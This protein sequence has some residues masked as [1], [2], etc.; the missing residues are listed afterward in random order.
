[1]IPAERI[2]TRA[3][4]WFS[5]GADDPRRRVGAWLCATA[6]GQPDVP[7]PD[8]ALPA[9]DSSGAPIADQPLDLVRADPGL[10]LK[11]ADQVAGQTG[12]GRMTDQVPADLLASW[13]TAL[14]VAVTL[15]VRAHD[16]AVT[17]AL[18]LAGAYLQYDW[19]PALRDATNFVAA[20]QQPDGGFGA[21]PVDADPALQDTVRVPLTLGCVWA[22]TETMWAGATPAEASGQ[23]G[24]AAARPLL[25]ATLT[26]GGSRTPRP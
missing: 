12:F 24:L 14:P 7:V 10:L 25:L 23:Q 4:Q 2:Y 11:L 9:V 3:R 16:L 17:S 22:L 8:V 19:H 20:Q 6:L 21:M 5:C 1:M 18:L 15:A 13:S 26:R